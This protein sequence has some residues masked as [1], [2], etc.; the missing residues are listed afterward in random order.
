MNRTF[1]VDYCEITCIDLGQ[2][3]LAAQVTIQIAV[4]QDIDLLLFQCLIQVEHHAATSV[5]TF[6]ICIIKY[7]HVHLVLLNDSVDWRRV[8]K[9]AV[10]CAQW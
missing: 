4:C 3:P 1:A 7:D 6:L 10:S 9:R 2:E 5:M 8:G